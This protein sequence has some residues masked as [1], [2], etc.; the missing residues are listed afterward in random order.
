MWV[1]LP[2]YLIFFLRVEAEFLFCSLL[3]KTFFFLLISHLCAAKCF[4]FTVIVLGLGC[5]HVL[6]TLILPPP[7]PFFKD[8]IYFFCFFVLHGEK[9]SFSIG[10]RVS[11]V[12]SQDW[13]DR[14]WTLDPELLVILN[15]VEAAVCGIWSWAPGAAP[16]LIATL[17]YQAF[18]S[19][20]TTDTCFFGNFFSFEG[21][22]SQTPGASSHT[23]IY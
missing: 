21:S 7:P 17:K 8:I 19:G 4:L 20:D 6:F 23:H 12:C 11:P 13:S 2:L 3:L 15:E 5:L 14:I 1:F 10:G 16:M 18:V 9:L 22:E